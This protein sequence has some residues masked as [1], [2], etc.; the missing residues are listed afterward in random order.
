MEIR[1]SGAPKRIL[2]IGAGVNGLS[3]AKNLLEDG[4]SVVL[5]EKS[6]RIGG[7]W[8]TCYRHA[9]LQIYRSMFCYSDFTGLGTADGA[10]AQFP[11]ADM[12]MAY[13]E[14][15]VA[16]FGLQEVIQLGTE[17]ASLRRP[18]AAAATAGQQQAHQGWG[19]VGWD[20]LLRGPS[21]QERTEHFD[22][23]AICSGL[24][25]L[26]RAR[27][28]AGEA[29][30]EGRIV[31]SSD[32]REVSLFAGQRVVLCGL[33]P[34]CVDIS[35]DASRVAASTLVAYR[36]CPKFFPRMVT[37]DLNVEAFV[38]HRLYERAED[39]LGALGLG[40]WWMSVENALWKRYYGGA[41]HEFNIAPF[42]DAKNYKN[43]F[44][45]DWSFMEAIKARRIEIKQAHVARFERHGVVFTD[46]TT[47]ECD[48]VVKTS[49]FS[50]GLS[51]LEPAMLARSGVLTDEG[52]ALYKDVFHHSL[53]DLA[54]VGF[55]F[56]ESTLVEG[57]MQ[58]RW[59]SAVASGRAALPGAN[60]MAA[61]IAEQMAV[62]QAEQSPF[63]KRLVTE[64]QFIAYLDGVAEE[65]GV[66][67]PWWL[68]W[69]HPLCWWLGIQNPY[70]YR[71]RGA[72]AMP[73]A[74]QTWVAASEEHSL[75][76]PVQ[77][78]LTSAALV[79][80][81]AILAKLFLARR[82]AD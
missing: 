12:V 53:P 6:A 79:G 71:I 27:P 40:E 55:V 70:M 10:D 19:V 2:V 39:V 68:K 78:W 60:D 1:A 67:P 31:H 64:P 18:A 50:P 34:S 13:L 14:A 42:D 81:G 54:F 57:E 8:A 35:T 17:V 58:G 20:A 82:S 22:G 49:G 59:F 77:R 37:A 45:H 24:D 52:L 4:H 76:K 38:S 41:L 63:M 80:A 74:V 73:D 26:P 9:K 15:Y 32:Y 3:T 65:A 66:A 28:I 29:A 48:V 36:T 47:R 7:V 61:R 16:R 5:V 69:R 62:K 72:G 56:C 75:V 21:G 30:F 46:G 44:T 43:G 25:H 33:G 51:M 11:S 23:V